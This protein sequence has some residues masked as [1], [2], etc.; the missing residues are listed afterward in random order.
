MFDINK[1]FTIEDFRKVDEELKKIFSEPIPKAIKVDIK[2]MKQLEKLPS[3]T[4]PNTS[5][6]FLGITVIVDESVD[7][8]E[9]VY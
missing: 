6:S 9:L 4:K 1:A 8:W 5:Y 7:G 2:T 3:T